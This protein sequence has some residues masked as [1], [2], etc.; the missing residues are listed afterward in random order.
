M[1]KILVPAFPEVH[2]NCYAL[3]EP[4]QEIDPAFRKLANLIAANRRRTGAKIPTDSS[5]NILQALGI[6]DE[7]KLKK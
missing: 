7:M 2:A 6:Y 5:Q 4:G 1:K 3:I